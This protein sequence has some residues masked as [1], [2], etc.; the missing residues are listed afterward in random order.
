MSAPHQSPQAGGQDGQE[1]P[2]ILIRQKQVLQLYA[3]VSRT[4]WWGWVKNG[5]APAPV[6]LGTRMVAWRKSDLLAWQTRQNLRPAKNR[7]NP[8]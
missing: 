8:A 5:K 4:T 6:R 2:E 7:P 1:L 3:P